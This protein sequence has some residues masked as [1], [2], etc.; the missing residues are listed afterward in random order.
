[1]SWAL[2]VR[3]LSTQKVGFFICFIEDAAGSERLEP[4]LMGPQPPF[5]ACRL[6]LAGPG[7][8]PTEGAFAASVIADTP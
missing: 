5:C 7:A 8:V 1:M 6:P 2:Y 4:T 3:F